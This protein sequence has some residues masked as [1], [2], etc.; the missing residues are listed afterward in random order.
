MDL[1][2]GAH[3]SCHHGRHYRHCHGCHHT[4]TIV[5]TSQSPC[6]LSRPLGASRERD[7]AH[8]FMKRCYSRPIGE[9]LPTFS[10][11]PAKIHPVGAG[12]T[13]LRLRFSRSNQDFSECQ[14]AGPPTM[15]GTSQDEAKLFIQEVFFTSTVLRQCAQYL[16][17]ALLGKTLLTSVTTLVA[18]QPKDL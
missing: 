3:H 11:I 6:S 15:L 12:S 14:R 17:P 16:L 4:A 8:N 1:S 2:C 7:H 13:S 10:N 9:N 5:N 18:K